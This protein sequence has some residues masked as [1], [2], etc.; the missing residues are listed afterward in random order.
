VQ[1]LFIQWR[2]L[3]GVLHSPAAPTQSVHRSLHLST[4]NP[5]LILLN[6]LIP[7]FAFRL[8]VFIVNVY[9]RSLAQSLGCWIAMKM[10]RLTSL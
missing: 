1:F 7:M 9:L 10:A 8:E 3:S 2:V 6:L 4:D 5:V